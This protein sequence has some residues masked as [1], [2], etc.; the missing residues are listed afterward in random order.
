LNKRLSLSQGKLEKWEEAFIPE[1]DLFFLREEDDDI[2]PEF[3]VNCLVFSFEEFIKHPTYA[4]NSYN[5][6]YTFWTLSKDI[7][8][9]I[10]APENVFAS[11]KDSIKQ[12]ILQ[13]QQQVGRGLIFEAHHFEGIL[14]EPATSMLA[15]FQFMSDNRIFYALQKEIWNQLP[16]SLK[17]DILNRIALKYDEPGEKD[18][19]KPTLSILNS[20]VNTY[21]NAHGP[22]C[23]SATLYCATS[24]AA[25]VSLDWMIDEWVHP[26][27]F[28]NGLTQLGYNKVPLSKDA[29]FPFDILIWRDDQERIKHASFHIDKHYFFNKNGQTFFNPWKIIHIRELDEEW[30]HYQVHVYRKS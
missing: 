19:Y 6:S 16:K 9:V 12:R 27:T 29:I 5:S 1:K 24:Q 13:I 17:S 22:N 20:Y 7:K 3:G 30:S 8:K 26:A 10:V 21:P 14:R 28:M 23:L 11:L 15:P 4:D 2:L 25:G 18:P